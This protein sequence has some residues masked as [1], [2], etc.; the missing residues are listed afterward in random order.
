MLTLNATQQAIIA[1]PS[2]RIAWLL[3]VDTDN[4]GII[5]YHYA[6]EGTNFSKISDISQRGAVLVAADPGQEDYFGIGTAL[7]ADGSVLVV[8]ADKWDGGAT[9]QGGVYIYDRDGDSWTQRGSV[10]TA[11]DAAQE[12]YFGSSVALSDNGEILAVGAC[13]WEGGASAQGGVYIYDRNGTSWDQ[14]GSVLTAPDASAGALFG[15]SVT[16]SDDGEVLIV[17]AFNRAGKGGVYTFDRNG[18]SWTPRGSVLLAPDAETGDDF[19]TSVALSDDG[20]VLVVGA[21]KW[22][23]SAAAQGGVYIFDRNG[24]SWGQRGSVLTALDAGADDLFGASVA[25]SDDG[26]V[27]VVGAYTWDGD[28]LADQGAVYIFDKNGD[29][30]IQRDSVLVASDAGAGDFF[31]ISMALSDNG[32]ILAVGALCWDDNETDQGGVYVFDGV[33]N[34]YDG[35]LLGFDPIVLKRACPESGIIPASKTTIRLSNKDNTI[36]PADLEGADVLLR[37]IMQAGAY[38]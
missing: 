6:F 31:G 23:G 21:A 18:T 22:T 20:N 26:D 14:R 36:D 16:L 9:D 10:L 15:S 38:V 2:K 32:G 29:S 4:D 3:E 35:K 8:G 13:T 5:D 33:N 17:G 37:L 28:S 19:G 25:M 11:S 7:S 1:S 12:D 24:D 27:L 34:V 30:W